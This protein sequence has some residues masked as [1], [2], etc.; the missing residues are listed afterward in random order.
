MAAFIQVNGMVV[1]PPGATVAPAKDVLNV[2]PLWVMVAVEMT[3]LAVPVFETVTVPLPV[4]LG[5]VVIA[6][7]AVIT[8]TGAPIATWQVIG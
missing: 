2:D 5:G 1:D 8:A 4:T 6:A 7:G 3:R